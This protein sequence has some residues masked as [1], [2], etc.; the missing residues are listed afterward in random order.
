MNHRSRRN[1]VF[2]WEEHD[3][4]CL[5][6]R[7][8]FQL[9]KFITSSLCFLLL[10]YAMSASFGL[11]LSLVVCK[12]RLIDLH[13]PGVL[14]NCCDLLLPLT[15]HYTGSL[16]TIWPSGAKRVPIEMIS[17]SSPLSLSIVCCSHAFPSRSLSSMPPP[18]LLNKPPSA[19]ARVN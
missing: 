8:I 3:T 10:F 4:L 7:F 14:A 6:K 18:P 2:C 11:A 5:Q 19:D 16:S 9:A 13:L 15:L 17:S 1:I 12:I